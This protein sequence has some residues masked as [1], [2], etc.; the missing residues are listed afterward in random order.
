MSIINQALKKAQREQLL[1][2]PQSLPGVR[3]AAIAAQP[4]PWFAIT[5]GFAVALGL[6]AVLHSWISVPTAPGG[7]GEAAS[8]IMP[9]S[10]IATPQL[11]SMPRPVMPPTQQVTII[12]SALDFDPPRQ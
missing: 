4:R 2:Q 10:T 7:G 3:H 6:G 8:E 5:A 9:E 11:A 12:P 1:R